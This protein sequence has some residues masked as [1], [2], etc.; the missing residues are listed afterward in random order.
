MYLGLGHEDTQASIMPKELLVENQSHS[1]FHVLYVL[2]FYSS[3]LKIKNMIGV[4]CNK[5]WYHCMFNLP[6]RL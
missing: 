3:Q 5:G 2:E 4:N 1:E 6:M